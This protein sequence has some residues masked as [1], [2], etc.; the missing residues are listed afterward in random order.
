[1]EQSTNEPI[2]ISCR[3]VRPGRTRGGSWVGQSKDKR[4]VLGGLGARRWGDAAISHQWYRY[5][6]RYSYTHECIP[7][8]HVHRCNSR[9]AWGD[10]YVR[11]KEV[12]RRCAQALFCACTPRFHRSYP[13]RE[14]LNEL[15]SSVIRSAGRDFGIN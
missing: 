5:R 7:A 4:V 12:K 13:Q 6:Y 9:I 15:T 8:W 3:R 10:R 11:R 14:A 1:M 2:R